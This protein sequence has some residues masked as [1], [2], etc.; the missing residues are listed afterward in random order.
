MRETDTLAVSQRL[1]ERDCSKLRMMVTFIKLYDF[2]PVL[3]TLTHFQG[4][5]EFENI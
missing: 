1:F 4:Q 2:I 3:M 5:I